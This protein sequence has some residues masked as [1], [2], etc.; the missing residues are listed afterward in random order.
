VRRALLLLGLLLSLVLVA[1]LGWWLFAP[2]AAVV[3]V[4]TASVSAEEGGA[5][6]AHGLDLA[7]RDLDEARSLWDEDECESARARLE[8]A[9]PGGEA[10]GALHVLLSVVCRRLGDVEGAFEHGLRG[11]ELLPRLGDAHHVYAE[12][13]GARMRGAGMGAIRDLKP[14]LATLRTAA[15]LDPANTDV[16]ALE[17]F[18][19]AYAPSLF[20]GDKER[21]AE[22]A[23]EVAA[24]DAPLGVA[25]RAR[26]LDAQDEHAAAIDLLEGALPEP[27]ASSPADP[28][29]L[30]ALANVHERAKDWASAD[31]AYAR[32]APEPRGPDGWM[33]VLGRARLRTTAERLEGESDVA[34]ALLDQFAAEAPRS[35]WL[36]SPADVQR[37]RGACLEDLDRAADA[38]TAYLAAL[39]LDP[40]HEG[41]R[42][43]LDAL[44]D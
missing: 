38:R 4:D 39:A 9:L 34:L 2:K 18:V 25:L 5:T 17:F 42:A 44:E 27:P 32:G 33:L 19:C 7:P 28:R 13:I 40:E 23:E 16:R 20:G 36:P 35:E 31:A 15:D 21:A 30:L 14:M 12:A 3:E 11:A 41:A 10:E 24:Q 1:A 43:A 22:L 29:L 26:L 37:L 8:A 6:V